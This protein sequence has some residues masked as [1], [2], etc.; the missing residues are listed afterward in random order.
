[1]VSDANLFAL[2]LLSSFYPSLLLE[3][4]SIFS[5]IT[6]IMKFCSG[7]S[8]CGVFF[9]EHQNGHFSLNVNAS[10]DLWNS[11]FYFIIIIIIIIISHVFFIF[12]C[13]VVCYKLISIYYF[14][15]LYV[16]SSGGFV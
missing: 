12:C 14:K 10:S 8:S 7:L 4:F 3:D 13:Y 9:A 15:V 2:F 1:M 16:R 11:F 6:D 5:F